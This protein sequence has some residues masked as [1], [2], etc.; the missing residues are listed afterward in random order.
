MIITHTISSLKAELTKHKALNIGFVPTMGALHNGHLCLIKEAKLNT[1]FVVCSIFVNPIQ[2]TN[3]SDLEKYPRTLESDIKKLEIENCD[4]LFLPSESE[5]Y[6]QTTSLEINFP[7]Q[8]SIMEGKFRPCHFNGVAI[9]VAKLFNFVQPQKAFFGQKDLQQCLIIKQLIETLSFDIELHI[10][11]TKRESDGLAMSSR[12]VR[13]S[14]NG[15]KIA[16]L[17]YKKI[18]S[19]STNLQD[20]E[21]EKTLAIEFLNSNELIK[22][23]YIEIVEMQSGELANHFDKGKKYGV[24]IA[25]LVDNVRLIDNI[26]TEF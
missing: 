1:D 3:S 12:N 21:L 25:A 15:R 5:I 22:V 24:C 7:Y 8:N 17:L 16:P 26:I 18:N 4:L 20:F 23:D 10:V 11:P 19:I 13:L 9:I 14:E 2:F 6:G